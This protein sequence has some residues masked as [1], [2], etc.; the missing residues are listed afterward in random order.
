MFLITPYQMI[1]TEATAEKKEI[2]MTELVNELAEL[3]REAKDDVSEK[4]E[5][6]GG[7]PLK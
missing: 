5:H 1:S 2:S 7:N 4:F 6:L 3:L